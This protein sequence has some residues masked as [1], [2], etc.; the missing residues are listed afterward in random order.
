MTPKSK[1]YLK[2]YL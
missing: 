1:L 2:Q